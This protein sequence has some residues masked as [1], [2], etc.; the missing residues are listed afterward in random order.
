[1]NHSPIVFDNL[2]RDG[3]SR[4]DWLN[5]FHCPSEEFIVEEL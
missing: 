4:E 5:D 3:M 2:A 1:M